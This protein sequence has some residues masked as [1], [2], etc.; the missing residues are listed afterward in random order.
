MTIIDNHP[1]I[2]ICTSRPYDDARG[3]MM[4]QMRLKVAIFR[5]DAPPAFALSSRGV[6]FFTM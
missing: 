3:V 6:K 1:L 2:C 4:Q 5:K